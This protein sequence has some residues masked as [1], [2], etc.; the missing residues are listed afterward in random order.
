VQS[1]EVST[2]AIIWNLEFND[3][4]KSIDQKPKNTYY[5]A[6]NDII[7]LTINNANGITS[8]NATIIILKQAVYSEANFSSYA[9]SDHVPFSVKFTG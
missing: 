7:N 6:G 4:V 2:N 3:G 1:T 8:K 5:A 9:T